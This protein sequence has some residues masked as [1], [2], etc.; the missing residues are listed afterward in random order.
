M[1]S[2]INIKTHFARNTNQKAHISEKTHF[3]RT[4]FL[5]VHHLQSRTPPITSCLLDFECSL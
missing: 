4:Q 3:V 1:H 5:Q 2:T